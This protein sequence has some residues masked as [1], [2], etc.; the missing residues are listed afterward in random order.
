MTFWYN[1]LIK[2]FKFLDS[3]QMKGGLSN[4]VDHN[5]F[6][7]GS[8]KFASERKDIDNEDQELIN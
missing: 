1:I 2:N 6:G 7:F 4:L 8:K 5:Y 3:N